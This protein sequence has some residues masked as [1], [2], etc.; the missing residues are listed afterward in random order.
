MLYCDANENW[1]NQFKKAEHEGFSWIITRIEEIIRTLKYEGAVVGAFNANIISRDLGLADKKEHSGV[2]G[3]QTI[4][5]M[6]IL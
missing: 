6:E 5:G 4:T 2:V 1:W 3:V